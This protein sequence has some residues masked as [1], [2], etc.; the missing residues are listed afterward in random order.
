MGFLLA[1]IGPTSRMGGQH[2]M[3]RALQAGSIQHLTS[4]DGCGLHDRDLFLFTYDLTNTWTHN[5]M[6]QTTAGTQDLY[7]LKEADGSWKPVK[8]VYHQTSEKHGGAK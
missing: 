2:D 5:H 7:M 8:I 1:S 3:T 4:C 6:Y